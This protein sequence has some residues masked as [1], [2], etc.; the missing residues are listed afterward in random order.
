M[1]APQLVEEIRGVNDRA[2][3]R[4]G[5]RQRIAARGAEQGRTVGAGVR[6]HLVAERRLGDDVERQVVAEVLTGRADDLE[7]QAEATPPTCA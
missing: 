3:G 1:G 6:A 4:I 5:Y 7:A 2:V